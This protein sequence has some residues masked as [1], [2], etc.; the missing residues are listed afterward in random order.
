M[1]LD[2]AL[3]TEGPVVYGKGIMERVQ[4]LGPEPWLCMSPVTIIDK[5][6]G[7]FPD[8]CHPFLCICPPWG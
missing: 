4:R 7:I 3:E 2:V 6:W 8:H 1:Y 5:F